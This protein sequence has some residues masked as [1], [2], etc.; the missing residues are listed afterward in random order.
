L[1]SEQFSI[2]KNA[3][4]AKEGKKLPER[5]MEIFFLPACTVTTEREDENINEELEHATITRKN[6]I[7][8]PLLV[9]TPSWLKACFTKMKVTS[10]TGE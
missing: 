8:P 5:V 6:R 2:H 9:L 1:S 7:D 4:A 3:L 10:Q